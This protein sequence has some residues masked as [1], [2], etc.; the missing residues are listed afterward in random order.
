MAGSSCTAAAAAAAPAGA[1]SRP[2]PLAPTRTRRRARKLGSSQP[3]DPNLK[4]VTPPD[5]N[6][7]RGWGGGTAIGHR[8][9]VAERTHS[10]TNES[11]TFILTTC[12]NYQKTNWQSFSSSTRTQTHESTHNTHTHFHSN[13]LPLLPLLTVGT[14]DE[15]QKDTISWMDGGIFGRYGTS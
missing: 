1:R 6:H 10:H 8:G 2:T 12:T 4:P 3:S 15:Y 14:L 13:T 9:S 5:V 7:R 11:C